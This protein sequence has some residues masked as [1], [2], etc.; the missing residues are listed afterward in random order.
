MKLTNKQ[1]K[2]II[3]E[4]LEAVLSESDEFGEEIIN[5]PGGP[6]MTD[7]ELEQDRIE[8]EKSRMQK[9][10]KQKQ[11]QAQ[12]FFRNWFK[13]NYPNYNNPND[14]YNMTIG[15]EVINHFKREHPE[16]ARL[17]DD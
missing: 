3:K 4:E 12:K 17:L 5:Y 9:A 11:S 6:M 8:Q 16:Q 15:D 7:A 10:F 1:L 13:E 14:P 2:Q